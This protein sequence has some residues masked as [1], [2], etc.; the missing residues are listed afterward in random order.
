LMCS[1]FVSVGELAFPVALFQPLLWLESNSGGPKRGCFRHIL[2]KIQ[3]TR[4]SQPRKSRRYTKNPRDAQPQRQQHPAVHEPGHARSPSVSVVS[5]PSP[6]PN[7]YQERPLCFVVLLLFFVFGDFIVC[8]R[9][10]KKWRSGRTTLSREGATFLFL[11]E[12]EHIN[13]RV[14]VL[15]FVSL[16]K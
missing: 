10:K 15:F 5:L 4:G 11:L 8:A 3:T 14:V 9:F 13:A 6:L 7:A 16:L 2:Q 12:Q 1:R